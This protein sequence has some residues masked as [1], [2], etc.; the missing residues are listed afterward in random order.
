MFRDKITIFA[1][2]Q[3]FWSFEMSKIG[4]HGIRCHTAFLAELF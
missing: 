1:A 3:E 4:V 2:F